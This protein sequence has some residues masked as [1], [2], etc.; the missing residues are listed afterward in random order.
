MYYNN[1]FEYYVK[2]YGPLALV[3]VL[4]LAL[5]IIGIIIGLKSF[6]SKSEYSKNSYTGTVIEVNDLIIT[7]EK[8]D[9]T[10]QNIALIGIQKSDL[11]PELGNQMAEDLVGKL[12]IVDFDTTTEEYGVTYAYIYLAADGT[13]YNAQVLKEGL[14]SLRAERNNINK[15]DI[16][17][18]TQI[19]ARHEKV[20]IWEEK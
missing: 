2:Q 14:A 8:S 18:Q 6:N 17:R 5:I 16:L 15:L 1:K 9:K 4:A 11:N 20:G 3:I 7:V 12:V 10:T 19:F 13:F